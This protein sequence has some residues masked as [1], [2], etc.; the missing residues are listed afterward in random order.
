MIRETNQMQY[1]NTSL[2][3]FLV[4]FSFGLVIVEISSLAEFVGF[5]TS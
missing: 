1:C 3:V 5:L 2:L 4:G